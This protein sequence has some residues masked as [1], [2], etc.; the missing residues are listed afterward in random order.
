MIVGNCLGRILRIGSPHD[1]AYALHLIGEGPKGQDTI[2]D[3]VLDTLDDKMDLVEKVIGQRVQK[4]A[5]DESDELAIET[6]SETQEI[7]DKLQDYAK[8]LN[9]DDGGSS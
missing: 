1:T 7:Y 4:D 6:E 9:D 8:Q 5:S 3:H 2:D